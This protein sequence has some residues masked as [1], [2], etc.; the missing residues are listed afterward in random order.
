MLYDWQGRVNSDPASSCVTHGNEHGAII[1]IHYNS[2]CRLL[3]LGYRS[4]FV[5]IRSC[6]QDLRTVLTSGNWRP[7]FCS[8]I[9]Q[10][11]ALVSLECLCQPYGSHSSLTF[12]L[13]C[14]SDSSALYVWSFNIN[15]DTIWTP[16][17]L[18]RSRTVSVVDL[19]SAGVSPHARVTQIALCPDQKLAVA[20]LQDTVEQ[21]SLLF[22]RQRSRTVGSSVVTPVSVHKIAVVDLLKKTIINTF[23]WSGTGAEF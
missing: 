19:T 6:T 14:G 1:K 4:G 7:Q 8:A 15:Y 18:E 2:A 23:T 9:D 17:A 3:V 10:D 16:E 5:H 20:V 21:Q 12:E 13:W 11:R 22:Q